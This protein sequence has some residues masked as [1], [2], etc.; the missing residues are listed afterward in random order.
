MVTQPVPGTF[1][2][3]SAI[4]THE[5]CTVNKVTGG[6][7]RCPCHGSQYAIADGSVVHGPAPRALDQRL[8]TVS[9]D[10]LLLE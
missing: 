2:G 8:I 7:I 10:T 4:C 1:R 9:G 6:V 5:G 3:F